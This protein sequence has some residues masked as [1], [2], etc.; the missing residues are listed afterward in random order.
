VTNT[1]NQG[2]K[3]I[4]AHYKYLEGLSLEDR[5]RLF[6][7]LFDYSRGRSLTKELLTDMSMLDSLERIIYTAH[8]DVDHV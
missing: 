4:N 6:T 1:D 3:L 7:L 2:F 8:F 5:G